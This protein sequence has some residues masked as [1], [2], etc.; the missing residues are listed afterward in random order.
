MTFL[1]SQQYCREDEG[2]VDTHFP[3][4]LH[5]LTAAEFNCLLATASVF[6]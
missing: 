5:I 4:P 1:S 2:T 6:K 3:H